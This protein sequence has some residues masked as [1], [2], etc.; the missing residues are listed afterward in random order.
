MHCVHRDDS[1]EIPRNALKHLHAA[2]LRTPIKQR[3]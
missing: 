1:D 3:G 2:M